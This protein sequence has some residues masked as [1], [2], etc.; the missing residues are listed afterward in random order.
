M[1]N[2]S[3]Q[4]EVGRVLGDILEGIRHKPISLKAERCK[5]DLKKFHFAM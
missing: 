4:E 2:K 3:L 1:I 5:A